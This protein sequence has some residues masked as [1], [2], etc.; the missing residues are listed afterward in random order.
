[1]DGTESTPVETVQAE[2]G[3]DPYTADDYFS[4]ESTRAKKKFRVSN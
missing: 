3:D 2:P 1:M 4:K